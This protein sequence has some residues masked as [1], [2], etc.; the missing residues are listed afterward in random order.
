L[1][2]VPASVVHRRLQDEIAGAVVAAL[3]IKLAA[4]PPAASAHRGAMTPS[5]AVAGTKTSCGSP[6]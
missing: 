4:G 5:A 1:L 2:I 3:K 6:P